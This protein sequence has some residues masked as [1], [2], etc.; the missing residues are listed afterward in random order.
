MQRWLSMRFSLLSATV[1]AL[2]GYVLIAAGDRVDAAL[3]GFTLTFALSISNEILFLVR[4][5]TQLELSLVGVERVHEY[6]T[7]QQEVRYSA[8]HRVGALLTFDQ[9]LRRRRRL[10][11]LVRRLTGRRATST[12]RT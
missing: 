1:V 11:N 8:Q 7:V 9:P 4:R 6:A 10:S 12:S 2:T 3:A 5:Y